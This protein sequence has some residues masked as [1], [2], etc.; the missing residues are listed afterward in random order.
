MLSAHLPL[1]RVQHRLEFYEERLKEFR[2]ERQAEIKQ[3][4]RLSAT[5]AKKRLVNHKEIPE[6]AA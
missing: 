2:K 6:R 3:I 5:L 4:E 1:M